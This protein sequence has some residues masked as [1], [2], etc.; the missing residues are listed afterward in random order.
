VTSI[1][2]PQDNFSSN[3]L[4]PERCP[5][6]GPAAPLEGPFAPEMFEESPLITPDLVRH[7]G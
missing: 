1:R 5:S 7:L 2:L 6:E 4:S 3:H